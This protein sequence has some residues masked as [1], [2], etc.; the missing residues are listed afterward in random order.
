MRF[1]FIDAQKAVYP[2][3]V[4]CRVM[5]VSRGGYYAW[6]HR[7]PSARSAR[8]AALLGKIRS[9]HQA[10]RQ[11]YGSPRIFDDLRAEGEAVGKKRVERLMRQHRIQG[12]YR[13][14]FV[15][16]TDSDHEDPVA[17]HLLHQ[18]FE[19][20]K[21][22]VVWSSD[23]T[24]L[25]T[26]QGWLYLAIVLDLFARYVV[27][28]AL[29]SDITRQLVLDAVAM[30]IGRRRPKPGLIFHSDRGSQY[31]ATD[32]QRLLRA[33]GIRASMSGV[34]NCYDNAVS[35]SFFSSFKIELGDAFP[36]RSQGRTDTFEFI[37]AFY[38][39]YRRHS[40][41]GNISPRVA[42]AFFARNGRRPTGVN[43]LLAEKCCISATMTSPAKAAPSPAV[44]MIQ[45]P[46]TAVRIQCQEDSIL[47]I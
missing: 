24:Q 13:K 36:S 16:T 42:E 22:D 8:D 11:R 4:L 15:C 27:G 31:A 17:P 14:R 41:N 2:L 33:H 40:F 6:R 30:A 21:P 5:Q 25:W 7:A 43:D 3:T 10:S 45:S 19:A 44:Q 9:F 18:R 47:S 12:K 34:G 29:R 32:T 38:N 28:W 46:L 1:C 26:P 20:A 39:P 23:M 37:E 35:E